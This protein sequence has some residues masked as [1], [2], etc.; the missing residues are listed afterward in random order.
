MIESW[1]KLE[2]TESPLIIDQYGKVG[3]PLE[4]WQEILTGTEIFNF[5][6]DNVMKNGL[7]E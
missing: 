5:G 2:V 3:I 6:V 7:Q 1:H 4:S